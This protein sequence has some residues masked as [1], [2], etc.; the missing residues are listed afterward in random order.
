MQNKSVILL[1]VIQRLNKT[2][3]SSTSTFSSTEQEVCISNKQRYGTYGTFHYLVKDVTFEL[4]A[5][6][7][8]KMEVS[9]VAVS[10]VS[11]YPHISAQ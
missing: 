11:P 10:T 5:F 3:D 8:S 9:F 6:Q 2:R 1:K 7:K 4:T